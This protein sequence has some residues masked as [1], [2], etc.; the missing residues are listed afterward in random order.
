MKGTQNLEYTMAKLSNK[1]ALI[2]GGN[3]GIGLAT[4]KL[5]KEEGAKV[6][7]TARSNETYE[8]TLAE[9]G[10]EFDVVQVDVG[11]LDEIDRLFEHV[12]AKY[13][14]IDV[15]FANAGVAGFVPTTDVTPEFFDTQFNTNVKGLYFTVAKA[16]PYLNPGSSVVLTASVVASK[17]FAGSSVY[18][19]TKAA[20]R[21][22][23]RSWT[24]EFPVADI[25]FNVL[26][27]GPI[28]TP[29]FDKMGLPAE[30]QHS[31]GES[32]PIKRLGKAEEM[33]KAALF[34]AS[35]D[36]SYVV[37]AELMAD[38]GFGQI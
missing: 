14:K 22:F 4:A 17:G 38:G 36:S 35:D 7:I 31:L 29:I 23:A 1:I 26:S 6:I 27:P 2:T 20:V 9:Y 32:T 33:A 3:S 15:L 25:R 12:K 18:S 24:A 13:G 37:G 16:L 21:N 5:F 11:K 10:K 8:K 34:L 28:A 30:G 19:A